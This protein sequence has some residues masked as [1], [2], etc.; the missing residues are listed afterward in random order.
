MNVHVFSALAD[1]RRRELLMS[2]AEKS[3]LTATQI[4]SG[5][6]IT[7]Q[8]VL[9]HLDILQRARLVRAEKTGREKFYYLTPEPLTELDRWMRKIEARWD[10]RLT[11]LKTLLESDKG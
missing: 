9:K 11:R 4:A 6:S 1:P 8:G 5:Y 3:P 10:K 2:L 7:R